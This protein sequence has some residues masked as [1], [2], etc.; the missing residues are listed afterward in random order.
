MKNENQKAYGY[1]GKD[2]KL[3]KDQILIEY[4]ALHKVI[5]R[6]LGSLWKMKIRK[7]KAIM[8]R[9]S[10]SQKTHILPSWVSLLGIVGKKMFALS[11][12]LD[13]AGIKLMFPSLF[14]PSQAHAGMYDVYS[15]SVISA[16]SDLDKSRYGKNRFKWFS[17]NYP[18]TPIGPPP[19]SCLMYFRKC[20]RIY[21][22]FSTIFQNWDDIGSWNPS[23][24][25]TCTSLSYAFNTMAA[26]VLVMQGARALAAMVFT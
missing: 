9:T 4:S 11:K 7:F 13:M 8:G 17:W 22:Y 25:E 3:T 24:W 1:H 14:S 6:M 21:L 19:L 10:N 5:S 23:L 26:D 2:F 20:I 16:S 18:Q 15:I 12:L